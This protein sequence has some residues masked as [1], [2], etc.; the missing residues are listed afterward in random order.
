MCFNCAGQLLNLDPLPATLAE[1]KQIVSRERRASDR[2]IGKVDTRVFQYERRVGDRRSSRD[3]Y[4]TVEDDMI[5]E[6]ILDAHDDVG[7]FED[8]TQI[9]ELVREL[10]PSSLAG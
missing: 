9:H 4:P 5:I 6:V 2:R 8:V 1:L 7:D 3:E 10:R